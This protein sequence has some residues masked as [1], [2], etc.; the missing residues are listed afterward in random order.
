MRIFLAA[1]ATLAVFT[2]AG[3]DVNTGTPKDAKVGCNCTPPPVATPPAPTAG[4]PDYAPPPTHRHRWHRRRYAYDGVHGYAWRR[5][6]SE[7]SVATYDYRSDS[8]SYITGGH[9]YAGGG[10]YDG[11][12][13]VHGGGWVDGYGRAYGG[14]DDAAHHETAAGD[15]ARLH[16]WHGY[17][18]DCPDNDPHA[19]R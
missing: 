10:A 14:G 16:P 2:V 8:H 19:R 15:R 6:Y 3:C 7:I 11:G 4:E 13:A 12:G 1:A 9:T 17:D 5:E 18:A